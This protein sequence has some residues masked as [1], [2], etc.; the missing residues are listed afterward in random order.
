M[1][2]R[3]HHKTRQRVVILIDEHDKRILDELH[4]ANLARTNRESLHGVYEMIKGSAEHIHFVFVTGVSVF[5]K[6]SLF[7]DLNSLGDISLDPRFVTVCGHTDADID[8][9]FAPELDGLDRDRIRLWYNG[10]GETQLYN[11]F[12]VLRL[13]R[14]REFKPYRFE[15][16]SPASSFETLK[17]QPVSWCEQ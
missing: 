17:T 6:V 13:L 16:G 9:V 10:Y 7:G 15:T 4:G 11:P 8:M 1:L 14:K 2:D 5:S 12:D 3:L